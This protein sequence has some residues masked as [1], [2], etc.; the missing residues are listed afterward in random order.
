MNSSFLTAGA[1]T[2][3][4]G[5]LSIGVRAKYAWIAIVLVGAGASQRANGQ[6]DDFNDGN[7]TGWTHVD[8]SAVGLP[9]DISTY[10]FPSDGLGGQAYRLQAYPPPSALGGAVGPARA[11]SYATNDYNRFNVAFDVINWDT[12]VD[13]AF[14]L[15]VRADPVGIGQTDGYVMNYNAVDGD[16]QINEITGESP[17]TL[18]E[19][20]VPLDP[21]QNHYRW[22]FMGSSDLL[23]GQ[24]FALP[25]TNNPLASVVAVDSQ[26]VSG[27]AGVFV[28]DRNDPP[29]YTYADA[30][31]DNYFASAPSDGTLRAAVV[32]LTPRPNESVRALPATVRAAILNRDTDVNP[33]SII[34]SVDGH[35][36]TPPDLTVTA[37]VLVP[38]NT[39]PFLGATVSYPLN[40][41]T[42]LADL[43]APH[44]NR[45]V[46]ADSTGFMQ[47]NEWT[48][49]FAQLQGV[50]AAAPGTGTNPGFSVRV[51]Q[52]PTGSNLA[53]SLQRAEAQLASNSTIPKYYET[54]VVDPLINYSENGPGSANGYFPD[55]AL[56]PGLDFNANGNDD[57]AMEIRTYLELPAGAV[58]LG[59]RCD[60]GYKVVSGTSLTDMSTLPL[61]FHNGGPADQTF[62]FVVPQAGLYPFRMVWYERGGGANVEW[63][64]VDGVS[65]TRTLINDTNTPTAIKAYTSV[66]ASAVGVT[67][68]TPRFDAGNL[69]LSF[70]SETGKTYTVQSSSDL[71]SWGSSGVGSV[72]G[73]GGVLSIP[74]PAPTAP[75][76]FYRVQTQ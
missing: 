60:D 72:S 65:G 21:G 61:G 4:R 67:I 58:R 37:E 10:S 75:R 51:V 26:H 48:F 55:D 59:V 43:T 23:V 5:L 47:T 15:L 69:V 22:V 18:A 53:N 9:S 25:D 34:L 40:N 36:I 64:S 2:A 3:L 71:S 41:L 44:T 76:T 38:N 46:F 56:I 50:N 14:G 12:S 1:L 54:N 19:I 27:K 20:S 74:I 52:A 45:L 24:V 6:S 35:V 70:Q 62:D 39:V 73:T 11:F 66:N 63:F 13:Q 29:Q 28:F 16:L 57:I 7:D 17:T 49:T 33:D 68:E 42:N 8:L 30:T 32:E 31:F